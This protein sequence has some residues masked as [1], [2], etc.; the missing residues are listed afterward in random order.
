MKSKVALYSL[1]HHLVLFRHLALSRSAGL[2][3]LEDRSSPRL[4]SHDVLW[5]TTKVNVAPLRQVFYVIT[6][7][8]DICKLAVTLADYSS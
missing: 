1:I 3:C 7:L 6:F 2:V 8:G 5:L 4:A